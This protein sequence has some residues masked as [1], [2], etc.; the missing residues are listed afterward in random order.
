[1]QMEER[2]VLLQTM[3]NYFFIIENL[4]I[5]EYEENRFNERE[6]KYIHIHTHRLSLTYNLGHKIIRRA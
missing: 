1:M 4:N 2:N 6:K 3:K 5:Q